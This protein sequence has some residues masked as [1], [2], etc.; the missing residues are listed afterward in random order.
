[1]GSALH[2]GLQGQE[3]IHVELQSRI[4]LSEVF[5]SPESTEEDYHG[6]PL[7]EVFGSPESTEEDYHGGPLSEV[8]GSPESTEE[9]Y[10]GGPLY[11]V[12]GSPES[13]EE[14]YHDGP[15]SEVFGS[16]EWLQTDNVEMPMFSLSAYLQQR[17][18]PAVLFSPLRWW[19]GRPGRPLLTIEQWH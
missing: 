1:M 16:P 12:F 11:E 3:G 2:V 13:T 19:G 9:G 7:S 6:G 17:R 14:D 4:H 15:L 18:R 5:G 10:H 8:F